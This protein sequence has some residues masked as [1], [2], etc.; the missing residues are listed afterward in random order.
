[1]SNIKHNKLH[2]W[3][4]TGIVDSEG[5]FSINY[6]SKTNKV[7]ASFKVTQK[8]H[9]L[10]ILTDL[11]EFFNC[12]NI[13]I[14]NKK[15]NAYK[16][17][18]NNTS[19]L[20]NI[21]I[22]HFDKYPLVGSK[23]LDFLDFKKIVL[24]YFEQRSKNMNN[25]LNIKNNMNR[26]RLFDERWNYL[27]K[28][29]FNLNPEWVQAFIDG[30][31]TFQCRIANYTNKNYMSVN[32]TLEIAQSSHDVQVLNA[33]KQFFGFGYIKPKYDINS[34]DLSKKS[35]S[36]NRLIINQFETII[37]FLDK[38][39]MLTRKYLDYSD[40]KKI[41]ELKSKNEHKNVDGLQ[42]MIN[43]KVGM[44]RNRL[45]N[46]NLLNSTDKLRVVNWSNL[47][48]GKKCYHTKVNIENKNIFNLKLL[49]LILSLIIVS[50]MYIYV[51]DILILCIK[52]IFFILFFF[53][54][55]IFYLDNFKLSDNKRI[56]YFQIIIF[57]SF[58]C[59]IVYF[60]IYMLF[61]NYNFII[62]DII[63]Y[64]NDDDKK[65]I[66]L[67]GKVVLNKDAGVEVAKGIS[68]LGSNIGLGACV[69]A[70]AGGVSKTIASSGIPPIQKA[71]LVIAGGVIGAVI[72]TGA[73]A[74]NAQKHYP[75]NNNTNNVQ[76]N[77]I[78][79]NSLSND[80]NKLIDVGNDTTP[81]EI[82]LQCILILNNISL[83]LII[84]L[85]MQIFFKIY[86]KD[87]PS[88]KFIDFIFPYS[89]NK[90]KLYIYKFINFN[91]NMS[92]IY[93]IIALILLFISLAGSTY[94]AAELFE[95]LNSYVDVYN[96]YS[97]K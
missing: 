51:Y 86:V 26:K 1:M 33:I 43:L 2:P 85:S 60:V 57:I 14:D 40:W 28:Q 72:H 90:I 39:P 56:K 92:K 67:Q 77:S 4:V 25:I 96:K 75:V 15:F 83:W 7:T 91:K 5:N 61:G 36:V 97:K 59:Y 24:N 12:G 32:P 69:G 10:I 74:I 58:I 79:P 41:I 6:N 50:F 68:S 63:S 54:F 52:K 23:H 45:L 80:I 29:I 87:K 44:N 94:F 18:V 8:D 17:T 21:I 13:N 64:L 76:S 62:N 31:G 19:D 49:L 35:R 81:L 95:N 73:S 16:Y 48:L 20:I 93:I 38:Y 89:N 65:N 22:P 9:S 46:S 30:E 3:W 11:K 55:T 53:F 84:I 71:G 47:S 78:D 88:L 27:N 70:L 66:T 37:N 82:I 34:L 42:N